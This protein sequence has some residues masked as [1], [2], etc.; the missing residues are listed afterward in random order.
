MRRFHDNLF[1]HPKIPELQ[2]MTEFN[3][4]LF[5]TID[6]WRKLEDQGVNNKRPDIVFTEIILKMKPHCRNF[7]FLPEVQQYH[8]LLM[9]IERTFK[10]LE[11]I[12]KN[13]KKV[14]ES[15]RNGLKNTKQKLSEFLSAYPND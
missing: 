10:E 6:D 4:L 1:T 13:Y 14:F 7:I 9:D 11:T 2:G 15:I 5:K 3:N 8:S 12:R